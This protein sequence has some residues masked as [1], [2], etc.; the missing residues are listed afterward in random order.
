MQSER[1][2][3]VEIKI[4]LESFTDYLKL[5]GFLGPIDEEEHH[6]NAFFDTPERTLGANGFSLRVRSENQRGRITVKSMVSQ[7][8]ALSVRNEVEADIDAGLARDIVDGEGD[9]FEVDAEPIRRLKQRFGELSVDQLVRFRNT[10]QKKKF[11]LGDYEY[12][13]EID[14]TEFSDGSVDYELEIELRDQGQYD[15]VIDNLRRIFQSLGIPFQRQPQTK[16]HR[17]LERACLI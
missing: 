5:I 17:A 14:K 4:Q 1:E 15:A 11:R 6:V 12:V 2:L 13:F 7:T 3:E 9:L 10:R 8:D 16:F